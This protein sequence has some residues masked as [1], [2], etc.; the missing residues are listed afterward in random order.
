[1][2]V[3]VRSAPN[4][5]RSRGTQCESERWWS[6]MA[7]AAPACAPWTGTA[8]VRGRGAWPQ[9]TFWSAATTGSGASF[10][11]G[12]RRGAMAVA[13]AFLDPSGVCDRLIFCATYSSVVR[14]SAPNMADRVKIQAVPRTILGKKVRQ[15]R[16][17]GRLPANVYGRAVESVAIDIEAREFIRN[18]KT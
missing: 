1:M 3:T 9:R 16:R 12:G 4:R 7:G 14:R 11:R 18:T 17:Q 5:R 6:A 10:A 15:L 2:A 13:S 8:M